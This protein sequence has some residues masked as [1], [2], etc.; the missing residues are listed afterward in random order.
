MIQTHTLSNGLRVMMERMP[1]LRSVSIGAWVKAGSMLETP[2][3]N[4]LAHLLEHMAFKR[5]KHRSARQ[6]AEEMDAIGGHMNAATSKLYTVYYAKVTDTDLPKA[7]DLLADITCRPTIDPEDLAKEK[8][9]IIEEI[10]MVD[11]S[12]EDTVYDLLNDALY[13]GQSL[14]MPITGTREHVIGYTQDDVQAFRQKYYTPANTVIAVAGHFKAESLLDMLEQQFGAW[15]GNNEADF[16]PNQANVQP[17]QLACDK[18]S[19]QTHICLGYRGIPYEAP[20]K[21]AMMA[22]NT[23]FGGGVSSRLFQR[24]REEKGLVYSIYSA[25]SSYPGCG[26]F[27]ICAAAAPGSAARVI[28]EILEECSRLLRDGV[29]EQ[30][31]EQAKAQLRTGFVLSQESAYARMSSLGMQSLLRSKV[32]LPSQTLRGIT[33]VTPKAV[34][35]MAQHIFTQQPSMAVV[36]RNA[37]KL[38]NKQGLV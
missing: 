33:R 35:A 1:H 12:P 4:G 27:A 26:D 38:V 11:D 16:P 30:E 20:G 37:E 22:L 3:E 2:S 18:R 31:L 9:V 6:L 15:Q 8:N 32:T 24:V 17:V 23:L 13:R 28:R 5:T 21:Y 34:M 29:S 14:S 25:P 36:G 10:A 7:I 19:E